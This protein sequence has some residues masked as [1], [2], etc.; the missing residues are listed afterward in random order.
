MNEGRLRLWL[1]EIRPQY[2]TSTVFPVV[3]GTLFAMDT[4]LDLDPI[5]FSIVMLGLIA[6]HAAA[7]AIND[8]FDFLGGT[9]SVNQNRSP[10]NGGTGLIVNGRISAREVRAGAI[11][12]FLM[13][14]A[15]GIY[16][17]LKVSIGILVLFTIG[18]AMGYYYVHPRLHLSRNGLG[19][20]AC[21]AAFGPFMGL[22]A[23]MAQ[24]GGLSW[25][26]VVVSLPLG[27]LLAAILWVNQF[28]DLEADMMTGKTNWV[29]RLG[30]QRAS[31]GYAII[32]VLVLL[33]IAIPPVIGIVPLYH[34][35]ALIPAPLAI[36][37]A[38][39]LMRGY[40]D[41]S[42]VLR[43]QAMTVQVHLLVGILLCLPFI[44][45]LVGA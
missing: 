10:F 42:A 28:P 37:T 13:G 33:T 2:F 40:D 8:Y 1:I 11:A 36:I 6:M 3:L 12:L 9:D 39:R 29:V 15:A 19:E 21:G 20:L 5:A 30:K 41:P 27:L 32:I 45:R 14:E 43:T 34:L 18:M 4:G 7:N 35:I 25:E 17:G 26:A 44:P 38:R 22:A 31:R 24:G 16:L 23:F